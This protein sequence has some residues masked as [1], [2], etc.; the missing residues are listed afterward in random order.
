MDKVIYT[1]IGKIFSPFQ[2]PEGTPIQP[3]AKG[4]GEGT[5]EIYPE[6][7]IGL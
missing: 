3:T 4:A 6:Y 1:P 7:Q 2:K 5:I